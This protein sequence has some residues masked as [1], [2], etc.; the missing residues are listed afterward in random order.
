MSEHGT[1]V[2]TRAETEPA[3]VGPSVE[4]MMGMAIAQGESGIAALERLVALQERATDRRARMAYVEALSRFRE[5]CPPIPRTRQ[6]T[7]FS[8]VNRA[9]VSGPSMYAGLEDIDRVAR[10]VASANGLIW[11][12]DTTVDATM[13]HITCKVLHVDGHYE[14]ATV[15]M[16]HESKAGASSQQKYAITQTYG[17]RYSLIAALGITTADADTDGNVPGNGSEK[18]TEGQVADLYALADEVKADL[19]KFLKYMGVSALSDIP[20]SD[21]PRA[22]S[23][24]EKKRSRA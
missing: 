5:Q 22:V 23:A 17:M 14:T 10:P 16:P 11:T 7:Q 20:V 2:A 4:D 19:P 1:S 12:W 13:M 6:N 24:L 8:K 18:I 3:L 15:S 9:G 21:Y